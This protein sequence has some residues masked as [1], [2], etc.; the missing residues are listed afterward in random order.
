VLMEFLIKLKKLLSAKKY[1][2]NAFLVAPWGLFLKVKRSW[3]TLDNTDTKSKYLD[4]NFLS[5][6]SIFR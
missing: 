6:C 2:V 3:G 4:D 1:P 5:I